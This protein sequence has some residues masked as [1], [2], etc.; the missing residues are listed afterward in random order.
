MLQLETLANGLQITSIV[1]SAIPGTKVAFVKT[2]QEVKLHRVIRHVTRG[3]WTGSGR[4]TS[5]RSCSDILGSHANG[6]LDPDLLAD[7]RRE[8]WTFRSLFTAPQTKAQEGV[9]AGIGS[10]A[11][12]ILI[13]RADDDHAGSARS[14]ASSITITY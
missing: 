12:V 4:A 8:L 1:Q 5:A 6:G 10:F 13:F 7:D 9:S 14:N 11:S 3:V 2:W